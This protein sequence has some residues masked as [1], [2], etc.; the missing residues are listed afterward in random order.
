METFELS[1]L[2]LATKAP[3]KDG[4]LTLISAERLE[5]HTIPNVLDNFLLMEAAL[6]A[7]RS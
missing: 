6:A 5:K 1:T 4:R 2:C 7:K 3:M